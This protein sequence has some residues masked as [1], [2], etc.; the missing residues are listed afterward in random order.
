MKLWNWQNQAKKRLVAALKRSGR[1][2]GVS[3]TGSGKT[4]IGAAIVQTNWKQKRVLWVAHRKELLGQA[5]SELIAAGVDEGE[6]G[7]LIGGSIDNPKARILIASV[8]SLAHKE[9]IPKVDLIVIDEAHRAAAN[10]YRRIVG[11]SKVPVLGLTATPWRLDGQ[12]LGDIFKELVV[13]A[14]VTALEGDGYIAAPITYGVPQE[15]ARQLVRGTSGGKDYNQKKLGKIMSK[16]TLMGDVVS[17]CARLAPKARTLVFAVNREHGRKLCTAFRRAGRKASYLDGETSDSI[18]DDML[19]RLR[20]GE[21]EVIVNVDVLSEGYDCP[22]VKCIAIARPTKSLTRFLQYCGRGVRKYKGQ[23][24]IILDH[25]GNCWRHGLPNAERSEMWTLDGEAPGS[26]SGVAPVKC[27]GECL[28]MVPS[29]CLTC[30]E[31]G[32]ELRSDKEIEAERL[33]LERLEFEKKEI[34][35]RRKVLTR[36]GIERGKSGKEL[37][38][39][40]EKLVA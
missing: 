30:P 39:W 7:I 32:A 11:S 13:L 21:T 3:P 5:K 24:P 2:V 34:E 26:G 31:C 8:Q 36:L 35:R 16:R 23:R 10:T 19:R 37:D 28:A 12:P 22:A 17:E 9:K 14:E 15:K 18:R 40:V 33:D 38:R 6:I 29:G 20:T 4:V 25:G 27:C 1:V